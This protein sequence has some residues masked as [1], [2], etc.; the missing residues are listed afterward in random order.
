MNFYWESVTKILVVL[1][2][3]HIYGSLLILT[4]IAARKI[5][6]YRFGPGALLVFWTI[7]G[8]WVL[9]NLTFIN[10]F[11][12]HWTNWVS[13][14]CFRGESIVHSK[15]DIVPLLYAY[16]Y[17]LREVGDST[18][19]YGGQ[20]YAELHTHLGGLDQTVFQGEITH[21]LQFLWYGY[22]A[23]ILL[24]FVY[25]LLRHAKLRKKVQQ[26]SACVDPQVTDMVYYEK[27]YL[28]IRKNVP[29]CM[30]Q[31]STDSGITGPF[32]I[33]I[34]KPEIVVPIEQWE[35]LD[36]TERQALMLHEL[37]HIR[38][39]DNLMNLLILMLQSLFWI[40]PIVAL[41]VRALIEDR[42]CYRD[43]QISEMVR[44]RTDVLDYARTIV[45]VA[46]MS[47]TQ[48]GHVVGNISQLVSGRLTK[49]IEF[50]L[51]QKKKTISVVL[52]VSLLFL[53]IIFWANII[54]TL[55]PLI[56]VEMIMRYPL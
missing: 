55:F 44:T 4:L 32:V 33:G 12:Y 30:V 47:L 42:E 17:P 14:M 19:T 41:G 5:A 45:T 36:A 28:G 9:C 31:A 25:H 21:A 24:F 2:N 48:R 29:V 35:A 50:L 18:I 10:S 8:A 22:L 51:E 1:L 3:I 56:Q 53:L 16:I 52:G 23:G 49:R 11:N 37:M 27:S 54:R 46:E 39:Q 20:I 34:R 13:K 15:L 7:I 6:G 43:Q 26:I 38:H 40:N